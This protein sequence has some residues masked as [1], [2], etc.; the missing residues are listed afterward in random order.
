MHDVNDMFSDAQTMILAAGSYLST[1]SID[2]WAGNAA[3]VT[4][5]MG[6]T[7][8]LDWGRGN[9]IEL[10]CQVT[11]TF[12]GATATFYVEAIMADDAGLTT[13]IVSLQQ[14]PGGSV[15]VGIPV[16]TLVAGYMFRFNTIP[17]GLSK[18][19]LGLRYTILTAA[20]TAG[21]ISAYIARDRVSS[22]GS[23]S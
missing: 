14:V 3:R 17:L 19:F 9:D 1:K 7:P 11:T 13:N 12:V 23:I 8:V 18:R 16:A 6:G 10:V 5:V 21:A 2:M 4:T 22:P 15:A 20:L